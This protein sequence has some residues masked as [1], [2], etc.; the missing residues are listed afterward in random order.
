M[1]IRTLIDKPDNYH[2]YNE[3]HTEASTVWEIKYLSYPE[4]YLNLSQTDLLLIKA[5]ISSP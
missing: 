1:L 3:Y 4:R 5:V 2:W